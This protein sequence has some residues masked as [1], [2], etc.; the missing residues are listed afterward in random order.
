MEHIVTGCTDCPMYNDGQR[1]EFAHYCKHPESPQKVNYFIAEPK[2]KVDYIEGRPIVTTPDFC[3]LKKE[4][5]TI[6]IKP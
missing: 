3:P 1:Y 4:P 2:I 6:S 5:I